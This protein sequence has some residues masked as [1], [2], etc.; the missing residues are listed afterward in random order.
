MPI[1]EYERENGERFELIHSYPPPKEYDGACLVPSAAAFK[2][3]DMGLMQHLKNNKD[4][5][6][7]TGKEADEHADK[8]KRKKELDQ[9]RAR[10]SAIEDTLREIEV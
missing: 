10:A 7:T 8:Q 9:D 5:V 2:M 6:I 4:A 1:F 3:V